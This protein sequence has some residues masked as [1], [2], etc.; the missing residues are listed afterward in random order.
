MFKI[1]KYKAPFPTSLPRNRQPA[2]RFQTPEQATK[3]IFKLNDYLCTRNTH[4]ASQ[5]KGIKELIKLTEE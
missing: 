3:T 1:F 2:S 5:K 4:T